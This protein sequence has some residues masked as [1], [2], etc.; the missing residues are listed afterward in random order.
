MITRREAIILGAGALLTA[1]CGAG[2]AGPTL[3]GSTLASTWADPTGTGTLRPGP[4]EPLIGRTEL[5]PA[6]PATGVIASLVHVT[7]AH[8]LDA[9]SPARVPFL[10][11]LGDPFESTF[12]PQETLTAQVLA[13][14][15]RAIAALRPDAV[16]QGGDLIDND[17]RNELGWALG[18]LRGGV[19]RTGRYY[20]VQ[21]AS[22][23][24][25]FYYRPDIDTPRHPG[26]LADSG[27]PFGAP[28]LRA[29]VYP[30]L[31]D[32]DILVAGE[33]APTEDTR[34]LAVGDQALW[35]LP[36]GLSLPPGT[37]LTAGG[38][39]DGPPLPGLVNQFLAQAL[40]GPKVRVPPD[41]TRR[42]MPPAEVVSLLRPG[43]RD[44]L[45][46]SADVGRDIRLI[47]LDLVR[48]RAGSGGT[49][50]LG[51]ASA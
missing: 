32:H 26:L 18:V 27:R 11:R 10:D 36:P 25:P 38:S 23:P 7:D 43:T 48:R 22:D 31:G 5:G 29:P 8:V 40:A 17:Q 2:G 16:I 28:G 30:V 35:E 47:V 12:R 6:R 20:G 19:V 51:P 34:A 15:T 21:L 45:D 49:R 14:T 3:T 9:S 33:L 13:D 4:G 46:Y 44:S 24:D 42:Q 41:P 39:P 1:G 37:T 50:T